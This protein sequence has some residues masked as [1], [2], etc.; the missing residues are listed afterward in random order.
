MII[1]TNEHLNNLVQAAYYR[2]LEIYQYQINIDNYNVMLSSLPADE[3]PMHLGMY[4]NTPIDQLPIAM[5]DQDVDLINDYQYRDRLRVAVR[6]ERAEQSKATRVLDA[7]KAQIGPEYD[8]LLDEFKA[9]QTP[10]A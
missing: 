4:V 6:T 10:A 1:T 3:W 5:T 2:E 7:L 8:T 9:A